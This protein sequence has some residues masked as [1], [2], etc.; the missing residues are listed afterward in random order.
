MVL[1]VT[2]W[3]W[4]RGWA[5]SPS[6]CLAKSWSFLIV[7]SLSG[8][9][10]TRDRAGKT[11]EKLFFGSGQARL[12]W[13]TLL[14]NTPIWIIKASIVAACLSTYAARWYCFDQTSLRLVVRPLSVLENNAEDFS[15]ETKRL[16]I[17]ISYGRSQ[18]SLLERLWE[19]RLI[20]EKFF[21]SAELFSPKISRIK[22]HSNC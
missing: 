20:W 11:V 1:V 18:N 19:I 9:D 14:A 21:N 7:S 5:P 12:H 6:N 13:R 22:W 10:W 16:S 4:S 3:I 8:C 2:E 17:Y 15:V